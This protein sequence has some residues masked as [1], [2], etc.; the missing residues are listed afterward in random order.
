MTGAPL[1][2]TEAEVIISNARRLGLTW[3]LRRGTV[4]LG[5]DPLTA[6][7][8]FDADSVGV[9]AFSMVGRLAPAQR[10]M[11]ITTSDGGNYVVGFVGD[12][13][14]QMSVIGARATSD[15]VL[16][17]GAADVVGTEVEFHTNFNGAQL[18]VTAVADIDVNAFTATNVAVGELLL[19]TVAQS[20][21]ILKQV[22]VS[23]DRVTAAQTYNITLEGAGDH[24][25]VMQGSKTSA[26][27]TIEF[28]A[29]HTGWS[30][31]LI[32]R[33]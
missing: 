31:V 4:N 32:D 21:Q 27:N 6:I 2:A 26:S 12:S 28:N 15:L 24:V 14:P 18:H 30:G 16:G 23:T 10:V 22:N 9:S 3:E 7:V 5:S 11:C 25:V 13:G 19:D 8:T 33:P 1:A 20:P 17:T 29:T